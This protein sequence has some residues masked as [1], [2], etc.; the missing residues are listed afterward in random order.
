MECRR[1]ERLGREELGCRRA[2]HDSRHVRCGRVSR[3]QRG[4]DRAQAS[5]RRGHLER[6]AHDRRGALAQHGGAR[7]REDNRLPIRRRGAASSPD[8]QQSSGRRRVALSLRHALILALLASCGGAAAQP[9]APATAPPAKPKPAV[10]WTAVPALGVRV[11]CAGSTSMVGTQALVTCEHAVLSV[12]VEVGAKTI[13]QALAGHE[14][15]E[16]AYLQSRTTTANR[17]THRY[18]K[19]YENEGG[20][21]TNYWVDV[22]IEIGGRVLI[23]Q[24]GSFA[25]DHTSPQAAA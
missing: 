25:S 17:T 5:R 16:K 4:G 1:S 2:L 7:S 10:T 21:G 19:S 6:R 14:A 24:T 22:M 11:A 8:E 9:K 20:A 13:E 23:C 18:R 12:M 15:E 3:A